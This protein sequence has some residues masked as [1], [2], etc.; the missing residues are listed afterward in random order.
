MKG[1]EMPPKTDESQEQCKP[2]RGAGRALAEDCVGPEWNE[3]QRVFGETLAVFSFSVEKKSHYSLNYC[4][5]PEVSPAGQIAL[6]GTQTPG[7]AGNYQSQVSGRI[8]RPPYRTT[9]RL[10]SIP[11]LGW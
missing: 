4:C 3:W 10:A 11:I 6:R 9:A 5:F 1:E 8:G 7:G 2:R